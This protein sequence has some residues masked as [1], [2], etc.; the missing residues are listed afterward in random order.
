MSF[1][2][3]QLDFRMFHKFVLRNAMLCHFIYLD[4]L[5]SLVKMITSCSYNNNDNSRPTAVDETSM[6]ILN[7]SMTSLVHLKGNRT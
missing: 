3:N 4:Y 6:Q 5:L 1:L 2:K 7:F